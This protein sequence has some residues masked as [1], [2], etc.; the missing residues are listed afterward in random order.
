MQASRKLFHGSIACVQVGN[1]KIKLTSYVKLLGVC[2]HQKLIFDY[3][4]DELCRKAGRKFSVVACLTK[5]FHISSKVPLFHTYI[6]SHFEY[7]VHNFTW[8]QWTEGCWVIKSKPPGQFYVNVDLNGKNIT[9]TTSGNIHL[10]ITI[11]NFSSPLI[12]Q[13]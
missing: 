8:T 6:L 7:F 5:T 2:F 11:V 13:L 1:N 12:V 10:S 4:V 9:L 3:H